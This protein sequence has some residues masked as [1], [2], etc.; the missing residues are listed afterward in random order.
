[1]VMAKGTV[2]RFDEVR[3]YGFIAPEGG[4]E[5]VFVHINDLEDEKSL[6]AP[7]VPVEF[8]MTEGERGYKA[9]SVR[10]LRRPA[11]TH[12]PVVTT[13]LRPN[14]S[15]ARDPDDPDDGL[16]DVLSESEFAQELTEFFLRATPD[17][18]GSQIVTLRRGLTGI[19]KNHG[20]VEA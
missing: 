17:L 1:M 15:V 8:Q 20:W 9:F 10:A 12:A 11:E 6:F 18:S 3:G 13:P 14:G 2:V 19:A 7:G 5:D 16:S 4:G